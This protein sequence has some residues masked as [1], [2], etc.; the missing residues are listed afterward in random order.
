MTDSDFDG[1]SDVSNGNL[2]EGML[3]ESSMSSVSSFSS[4]EAI[5]ACYTYLISLRILMTGLHF[6]I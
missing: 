4:I 3:D 5:K 2:E 6:M 1:F